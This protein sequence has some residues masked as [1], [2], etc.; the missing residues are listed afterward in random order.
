MAKSCLVLAT[1]LTYMLST[2]PRTGIRVVARKSLLEEFINVLQSSKNLEEKILA[3]LAIKTFIT[4][5]SKFSVTELILTQRTFFQ[6]V[7]FFLKKKKTQTLLIL[8]AL[9]M[10]GA[11]AKSIYK[12]LREL[13]RNSVVVTDI[14]KALTNLSSVDA[15]SGVEENASLFLNIDT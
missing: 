13:K 11:Y 7:N 6:Y 8:A 12:T 3:T 10:L 4:D 15:E 9:E 5:P 2:L 1:W 14:M